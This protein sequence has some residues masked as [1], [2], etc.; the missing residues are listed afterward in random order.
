MLE[1][2]DNIENV[3]KEFQ[4]LEQAK[5]KKEL[6]AGGMSEADAEAKM[7]EKAKDSADKFSGMGKTINQNKL[8]ENYEK[9]ITFIEGEYKCSGMCS[10]SLFYLTQ[11]VELGPPEQGCLAPFMGDITS[12][13]GNLGDAMVASGVFFIL[14]IFFIFPVCCYKQGSAGKVGSHEGGEVE[15][16]DERQQA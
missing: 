12:L 2:V 11:S 10:S 9:L 3:A 5:A 7:A 4:I 1:C 14:M 6:M 15:M 13:I 16:S 8:D